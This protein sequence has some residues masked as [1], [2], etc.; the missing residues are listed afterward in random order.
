MKP[1]L[2]ETGA[3]PYFAVV[4]SFRLRDVDLSEDYRRSGLLMDKAMGLPGFYGDEAAWDRK[5]VPAIRFAGRRDLSILWPGTTATGNY[6]YTDQ[7]RRWTFGG[8]LFVPAVE[9]R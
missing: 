2:L 7:P 4:F 3:P 8:H 9:R 1:K 5:L 6:R